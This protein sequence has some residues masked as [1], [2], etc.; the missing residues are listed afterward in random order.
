MSGNPLAPVVRIPLPMVALVQSLDCKGPLEKEWQSHCS[1]L[2]GEI[3]LKRSLV[4]KSPGATKRR[5]HDSN[6]ANYIL[7]YEQFTL[8]EWIL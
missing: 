6:G 3:I 8:N 4:G 1:G 7:K 5:E 2:S